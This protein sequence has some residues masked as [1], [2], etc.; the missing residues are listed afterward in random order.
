MASLFGKKD[1]RIK[2]KVNDERNKRRG[3][4]KDTKHDLFV[5]FLF[6]LSFIL[7]LSLANLAGLAGQWLERIMMILGGSAG[8]LL[9]F[10]LVAFALAMLQ[11][12][13]K[14]RLHHWIGLV[15][16]VLGIT[17]LLQI[18]QDPNISWRFI[19][20][21]FGGG[22]FG[23]FAFMPLYNILGL[24]ATM[25]LLI[26]L[27]IGG[28]LVL[29]ETTIRKLLTPVF[30]LGKIIRHPFRKNSL[31][32]ETSFDEIDKQAVVNDEGD[33]E[34]RMSVRQLTKLIPSFKPR[35]AKFSTPV[36]EPLMEIKPSHRKI[37]I[38]LE[39]L[40]TLS[41]KPTSGDIELQK[42]K[43][44]KALAN[45]GIEVEMGEISIGPTVTQYTL[46]PAEGV[47]LSQITALAN[48]LALALAA[49]PIRIEAPIP[50]KALV[51]IEVPNQVVATVGLKE[52]LDSEQFKKRQSNL[53]VAL[54]KDV[55]GRAWV[56]D[57][58]TMPH[59]LIAGATGSGKSVCINSM[60]I[61]L[62]YTN[63]PDDLKFIIIDPKRVELTAYNQIPH[64]LTPV[65]TEIDKTIAA[66]KW[67]VGE[68]NRRYQ[69]LAVEG[70]RNIQAFNQNGGQMP[71]IIVV[72]D[73]LADLMAVAAH[74]V[75]AAIIRLA[76]TARAVG[77][78]LIVATQR[79]S[80]DVITGLIKANITNRIAFAVAS[81]IDS[82]TI[83]D[84]SGAEKLLGRGDSL[85]LS[86]QLTKPKRLQCALVSDEEIERIVGYIGGQEK[87]KFN[88][89]VT[90]KAT[91]AVTGWTSDGDE[92]L[93]EAKAVVVRAGK[94]SASLLQ[95]RLRVGYARAARLLDL[96]EEQDIIGPG[97][98][99]KPR[100]VLIDRESFEAQVTDEL[101][102]EELDVEQTEASKVIT[103]SVEEKIDKDEEINN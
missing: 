14:I 87:P 101:A 62:L 26:A 6:A 9:P 92:L 102:S 25:V 80:V 96:L 84:T 48:D 23:Y 42:E 55:A 49:H 4:S 30:F 41:G 11:P 13:F 53:T 45:F 88:P 65:I 10:I 29:F 18:G 91:S 99:A 63:S 2:I 67:V 60:L 40:K 94:A 20:Q 76:Q 33:Q 69:T 47:K 1:Q 38:P 95:R 90:A 100:D 51:G 61:S 24:W 27:I 7:L 39:L 82:R 17:G 103:E 21:G 15:M 59:L 35:F 12:D 3:L 52:I 77:I 19:W 64:L 86:P 79:P 31:S 97:D 73:E 34:P 36:Q 89:Q 43:I 5:F 83:L 81:G 16:V 74:D 58:E 85:Y 56:A 68:M 57:L 75:E 46:K 32:A 50:G 54:G 44:Q 72:I 22:L 70:K 98:G 78:H 66:L 93:N 28:I 37:D 71:Y 8:W